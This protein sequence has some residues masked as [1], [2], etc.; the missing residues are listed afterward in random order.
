M[1]V[2][3]C[4]FITTTTY[5]QICTDPLTVTIQG[6]STGETLTV[7]CEGTNPQCNVLSGDLTGMVDVTVEGG[8]TEYTYAWT[9]APGVI[10]GIQDQENLGSGTY[11][12]TVTDANN[13][14][15]ECSVTL[16]EPDAV[17][18]T[19]TPGNPACYTGNT[20]SL[21]GTIT[22]TD[23]AG[24]A[25]GYTFSWT[26]T[27]ATAVDPTAQDQS[28]LGAGTY[29]VVV[30][31][32]NG[33]EATETFTLEEPL[34]MTLALDPT[35]PD[36]HTDNTTQVNGSVDLTVTNGAAP[37]T[38]AWTGGVG[39]VAGSEDQAN[40]GGGTYTV[41]V[42]DAS[43]CTA[44]ATVDL[45]E[46]QPLVMDATPV[47]PDCNAVDG[48]GNGSITVNSI[49]NSTAPLSYAW[50]GGLA[51]QASQTGLGAGSYSVTVT[52]ANGCTIEGDWTLAEPDAMVLDLT[53]T[54]PD[55]N[56]LNTDQ[57]NGSV[58][59]D[60]T[61]GTA[62]YQ[63][64]WTGGTITGTASTQTVNDLGEG[65][66]VVVVT[67]ALGCETT[68][69]TTLT[70]PAQITFTGTPGNPA[71]F[72]GNTVSQDGTITLT[73]LAGGAGG[74]TFNWT[75]T[76]VSTTAQDQSGLGAGTYT[77]IVS[78]ANGCEAEQTF[79][80][81]EPLEMTVALDA[82]DPPCNVDNTDQVEG[83]IDAVV[84]N[85]NGPFLYDWDGIGTVDGQ[86]SQSN[87]G[88]GAYSV[89]VTDASGC[90]A[91]ANV[92]L[93]EPPV[94]A[95]FAVAT[96][97]SCHA[98]SY[99]P[100]ESGDGS[101]TIDQ[102]VGGTVATPGGYTFTWTGDGVVPNAQNQSSLNAGTYFLTIT[103]DN[104][105]ELTADYTLTQP[106]PVTVSG[107]VTPLLCNADSGA[108]TGAIDITG[109]GGTP[110]STGS[111]NYNWEASAGGTLGDPANSEDQTGLSAGTY[112]VTVTDE[113]GCIA[114]EQWTLGEPDAVS[115]DIAATDILCNGDL[116]TITVTPAG[117]TGPYTYTITGTTAGTTIGPDGNPIASGPVGPTAQNDPD[118][119]FQV[120]AGTYTVEVEDANGC[121]S[122][123]DVTI[124]QPTLLVA[125]TCV[126]QDECQLDAGEIRVCAD[127]G[128]GP[129]TITWEGTTG[130]TLT[131]P[132]G[133]PAVTGTV[134]DV[135]DCVTFTG[136]QG[137]ETYVF[138]VTDANGCMVP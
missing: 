16:T 133:A 69:Q 93:V 14:T 108:P 89:T 22:L 44:E 12:V 32:V 39:T 111:Y 25:G 47:D 36:C 5:S 30:S 110:L 90:T 35:D 87:L 75:G 4:V 56:A 71:C 76:G 138:T 51:D 49:A 106:D 67:D 2:V 60:V 37:F 40:V 97:L 74:Y 96:Q 95:F 21:D 27:G 73:D 15:G 72:S 94:I 70:E 18:F 131:P 125:G 24:G 61:N 11:S 3:V 101:I 82:T 59:V 116:S 43:G 122:S 23:I 57:V 136:A 99:P 105:C 7:T 128:V 68:A 46:P 28:G 62:P 112:S 19:G 103:D 120:E 100:G 55:C 1:G 77:V 129:Y 17:T 41:L 8:T 92:S 130:G 6:S 50:S 81:E 115:C 13:C 38:Y 85:G 91:V 52:D 79:T 134:T 48:S 98:D 34:E 31:D 123:C 29:T 109:G 86:A 64:E 58:T 104:G 119:T 135:L 113:N 107:D 126:V 9:A 20:T 78:D 65:T 102:V 88:E 54:D 121:I 137:G 42:T 84:T 127:Q 117:G 26:G 132:S 45:T 114:T 10:D 33:C 124:D 66:Y 53:P 63:Y 83:T 118:N 80:L